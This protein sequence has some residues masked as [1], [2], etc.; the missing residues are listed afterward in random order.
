MY[1]ILIVEDDRGI[2]EAIKEQ[3]KM[4]DLQAQCVQNFR[5]V[6][7]DFA[8]YDP[9]LVLLDIALPFFNGYHWCSEI[10]KVSKVPIIFI[11]S[12]SDNMNIVMAMNL[13]ADD[14]IAKPFDQ[15]VLMAKIQAMLRRTYDFAAAVPVL[16]HRGALLN[17]GD[18]TLTYEG[19]RID[20]TKN[21]Y[22]ILL[23]LM[24]NK[25]KVV[26]REKLME[27]L[28]ETDSFVDENTLTVN[29]N[30]LRKKLDAV[31]LTEFITTKFGVGYI[32]T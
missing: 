16:E 32:I 4:W 29:V 7:A 13:G 30:R 2:A 14:F 9:H 1:K 3:A 20:L 28:W 24:E 19:E 23:A 27:R 15:G 11:S 31:G 8:D 17:T 5:N 26:S 10:R 18:N 6:L 22:R 25:G 21:E 12:A